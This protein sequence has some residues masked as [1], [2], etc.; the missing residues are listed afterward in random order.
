MRVENNKTTLSKNTID[1]ATS[2]RATGY[3]K[4]SDASLRSFG[5]LDAGFRFGRTTQNAK[6]MSNKD[7]REIGRRLLDTIGYKTRLLARICG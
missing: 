4:A 5:V 6:C 7:L 3:C 1:A 2:Y